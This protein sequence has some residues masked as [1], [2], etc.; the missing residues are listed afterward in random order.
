M[1]MKEKEKCQMFL[2]HVKAKCK[3]EIRK[4]IKL[5]VKNAN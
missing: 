2:R 5:K 3:S 1:Y 4:Y